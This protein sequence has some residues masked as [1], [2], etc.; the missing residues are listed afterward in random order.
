[1]IYDDINTFDEYLVGVPTEELVAGLATSLSSE[2]GSIQ[3]GYTI[4][5]KQFFENRGLFTYLMRRWSTRYY[6]A[7][8]EGTN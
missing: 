7:A 5:R 1:M 3:E 2:W 6:K 4:I 8:V